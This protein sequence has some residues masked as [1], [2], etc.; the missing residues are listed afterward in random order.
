M[1]AVPRSG[2]VFLWAAAYLLFVGSLLSGGSLCAQD[3]LSYVDPM[4]GTAKSDVITR[5]GNEGGTYP[6]AVAP[7]GYM[8]VTPETRVAGGY[9]F[10]DSTI[11]WFSCVHHLSGYPNG[12]AGEIRVMPVREGVGAAAAADGRAPDGGRPLAVGGIGGGRPFIHG[13]EHA[14]AGYYRVM[15]G[16]DHTLVEATASER[17]GWWRFTY[18]AGVRPKLYI[19]GMGKIVRV[20]SLALQGTALQAV[21]HFSEPIA[22]ESATKDGEVL[23]FAASATGATVIVLAV[24]V[25]PVGIPGAE[26]NLQA[27]EQRGFDQVREKTRDQWRKVLSVI[28]VE[29]DKETDK[30]IFY[31][32]LYH[33]LLLPW[34]LSDVEGNYRGGD[35]RI[36]KASGRN[37]Y[38]GFSPWDSFRSLHPLLT[39]LFP[40][41]QRDM[42]LSMLDVYRQT[43]HLPSDPMTGNHAV[44]IIVDACL[45]GIRGFDTALVWQALKKGVV[46]TP[47]LQPDRAMY[48]RLGYIPF[49]DP[50]SVTRTVEYA[51]DDWVLSRFAGRLLHRDA[52]EAYLLRRSY[53]YRNLFDP[54]ALFL[55]PR[56]GDR[57]RLHPGNSGYKEGD[58]WVYTYF[59]PQHPKDLVNLL[60]GGEAFTERLDSAF[61]RQDILFDNE[62]VFH[63]PYLFNY[64]GRPG[65]TQEWVSAFRDGRFAATPGGLP[66]N[67]DLGAFSSWYVF[68]AMGFFPVCPGRP[69]YSI[70]TPLFRSVVLHLS[71]DRSFT[72]RAPGVDGKNRYIRSVQVNHRRYDR[73]VLSH[74]LI[75]R[76]GE[77]HFDMSGVPA[78]GWAKRD[79]GGGPAFS[80]SRI[81]VS[82]HGA[83]PHELLQIRFVLRNAGNTGTK[84]VKLFAN[85]HEYARKNC[86][87][88]A[89]GMLVDSIGFRLYPFGKTELTIEGTGQP[90]AVEVRNETASDLPPVEVSGLLAKSLL[91]MGEE[92]SISFD[93]QNIGGS[94]RSLV[95]PVCVDERVV[96]RDTLLLQPGEKRTV[97]ANWVP[98]RGGLQ[99]I[100]VNEATEKFKV[101]HDPAGSLLLSLSPG[102]VGADGVVPD[103]SGFGNDGI[104]KG[105]GAGGAG[106][107]VD[108]GTPV[109]AGGVGN[110]LLRLGKDCYV[111]VNSASS[112]DRMGETITMMAWVYPMA[113]S[114]GLVDLFTKGDNHVL[115]VKG[116]SLSFFAGGWGRGD[117]TV[118]LPADWLLHWHSIAGVCTGEELLLYIDGELKGRSKVDGKVNLS[119]S[120]HWVLGRNEEFPGQ[121]I[122]K[123]YMDRVRVWAEALSAEVIKGMAAEPAP[124]SVQGGVGNKDKSIYLHNFF[125]IHVSKSRFLPW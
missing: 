80:F 112:L 82:K 78:D 87:V 72:I 77:I 27:E 25:S 52:D 38:G 51:Y 120:N 23:D 11:G 95:V 114:G 63:I 35:G 22:G 61:S 115:Q 19:G 104:L 58:A 71:G 36:H 32:A 121:R 39:L 41:R 62:T 30:K 111:E 102:K 107:A 64:A 101:Y 8:Q 83:A 85:G 60:G 2:V 42:I 73:L 16:D 124:V 103:G 34:I 47:Y 69:E 3:I 17:V 110:G 118:D 90:L 53:N 43:G 55:L 15:F 12:S 66:G 45:K 92:Q 1:T 105:C 113:G 76:G 54:A 6:G 106:L 26:R 46:D 24:S 93:A 84:I 10:A 117:C 94:A 37:E 123:G 81:T 116:N 79:E 21:L 91:R 119:V 67:D 97:A 68:S 86:L 109:A 50:E 33:S 88:E 70:G 20:S 74:E 75:K 7:W 9:D 99:V 4:I 5:W 98:D 48:G 31:T 18:P 49:T 44:P 122:F 108:A 57:F 14:Q 40:D 29:D 13:D 96:R 28:T 65:K 89:G 125:W 59:V 100:R 56:E